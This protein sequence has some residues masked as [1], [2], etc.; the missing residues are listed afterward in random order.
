MRN[1]W[2]QGQKKLAT[3]K[4][5]ILSWQIKPFVPPNTSFSLSV[6]ELSPTF[7]PP[8]FFL[9]LPSSPPHSAPSSLPSPSSLL[10]SSSFFFLTPSLLLLFLLLFLHSLN[11]QFNKWSEDWGS[12]PSFDNP[13]PKTNGLS[14][15]VYLSFRHTSISISYLASGRKTLLSM[16]VWCSVCLSVC[17]AIRSSN[18]WLGI[19][20]TILRASLLAFWVPS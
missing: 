8:L 12:C 2:R 18:C 19:Y 13:S 3:K 1:K 16:L 17:L 6:T 9:L 4:R 14:L 11:R 5:F 7:I 20:M 15:F 10:P